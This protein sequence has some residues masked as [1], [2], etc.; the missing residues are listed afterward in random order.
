MKYFIW[1]GPSN[2]RINLN[3][4]EGKSITALVQWK[5]WCKPAGEE[6]DGDW[7]GPLQGRLAGRPA[8][9]LAGQLV[10]GFSSSAAGEERDIGVR[11]MYQGE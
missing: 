4:P 8:D 11:R 9:G 7:Q 10:W 6:P 1:Y 5:E 3:P 2:L